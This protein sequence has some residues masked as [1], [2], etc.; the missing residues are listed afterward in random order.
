MTLR[1]TDVARAFALGTP[2]G[3]LVHVRRGDTDT[4]RLDTGSGSY[5]V[6]RYRQVT[7][8]QFVPGALADQ[9]AVAM[10]FERRAL[11]AGIDMAEPIP[12]VEPS[13][14]WLAAL[15]GRLVRVYRWV[16]HRPLRSGEDISGWLGRTMARIHRLE[17]HDRPG[18]PSWWRGAIRPAAD[19]AGWLTTAQ[20]RGEPWSALGWQRLPLIETL[21][22]RLESVCE[23]APDCV[24][25]H[26][27]IKA[28]NL[29]ITPAGPVLADWDS[30]R[31]DSAALEVGRV[32]HA[33]GDTGRIV[34]A[35]TGAGGDLGWAGGDL[36][37][38]VVRHHLQ[39]L[40]ERIQVLLGV[41]PPVHW[42]GDRSETSRAVTDLL[43]SLDQLV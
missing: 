43:R 3:Q 38:S 26:G 21:T 28:H 33:F 19:W 27:D 25:T 20:D 14:G 4:W 32:A 36:F 39:G 37:L 17:P 5:L 41:Q 10:A 15:D 31:V 1:A 9:L 34:A 11:E 42:M 8:G 40:H 30:V 29:L 24:T 12:P 16:D 35:Y 6:K 7:D 23:R 22:A 13:D 2:A 18:L